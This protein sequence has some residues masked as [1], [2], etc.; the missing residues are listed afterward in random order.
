[1]GA[2]HKDILPHIAHLIRSPL[3]Q[4]TELLFIFA[5]CMYIIITVSSAGPYASLPLAAD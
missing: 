2:V 3:L 5:L 1:M 4:G